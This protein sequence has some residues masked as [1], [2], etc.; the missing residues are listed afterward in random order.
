[1]NLKKDSPSF[2]VLI[3]HYKF[4]KYTTTSIPNLTYKDV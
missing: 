3:S 2:K 4:I 1:M